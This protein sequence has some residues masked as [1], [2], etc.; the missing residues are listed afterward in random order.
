MNIE[1]RIEIRTVEGDMILKHPV[2]RW[3]AIH[4]LSTK[5]GDRHQRSWHVLHLWPSRCCRSR[6]QFVS[7]ADLLPQCRQG[8]ASL[9]LHHLLIFSDAWDVQSSSERLKLELRITREGV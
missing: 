2:N 4:G 9:L 3:Q 5:V 7:G 6:R 1:K 8:L